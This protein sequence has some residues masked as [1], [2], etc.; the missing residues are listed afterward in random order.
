[1]EVQQQDGST[2]LMVASE[3]G[4]GEV[5]EKLLGKTASWLR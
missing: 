3:R 5:V 4:H 2:A 1:M